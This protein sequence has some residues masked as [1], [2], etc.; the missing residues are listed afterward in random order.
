MAWSSASEFGSVVVDLGKAE[1]VV[2]RD[3]MIP[4]ESFRAGDRIRAYIYDVRREAARAAD[5]PV[6]QP[7][8][9]HGAPVRPGS[10]GNL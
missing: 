4:R 3:E 5:F 1:G 9:I 8:P 10:A 6:A 2:R 7:S